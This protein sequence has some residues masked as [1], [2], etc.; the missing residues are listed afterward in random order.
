MED[1]QFITNS[2]LFDSFAVLYHDWLKN[3]KKKYC[4]VQEK[5]TATEVFENADIKNIFIMKQFFLIE[6]I[7][8]LLSFW[9][10]SKEHKI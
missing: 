3:T 5:C 10:L 8:I 2:I 4:L 9:K 7:L 1:Q 6:W